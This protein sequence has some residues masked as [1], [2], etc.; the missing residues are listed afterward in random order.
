M[1]LPTGAPSDLGKYPQLSQMS[2]A[3]NMPSI[4]T[5]KPLINM[6]ISMMLGGSGMAPRPTPGQSILEAYQSRERS[7]Q[8]LRTMQTAM[9]S[10]PAFAKFGGMSQGVASIASIV[11]GGPD[12]IMDNP[13]MRAL[14]GGNPI[15]EQMTTMAKL[16]GMTS[17]MGLGRFGNASPATARN[18]AEALTKSV[19]DTKTI[20]QDD[21]NAVRKETAKNV[22]DFIGK[23]ASR[24]ERFKEFMYKDAAGKEQFDTD[25]FEKAR[26]AT[27]GFTKNMKEKLTDVAADEY[28][29]VMNQTNNIND[30]K[31][32]VGNV[33]RVAARMKDTRGFES[34]D[35]Q[36]SMF[37]AMDAGLFRG[38]DYEQ[39]YAADA[40]KRGVSVTDKGRDEY[41]ASAYFKNAPKVMNAVSDLTG[42][43]TMDEATG[44]L[45]D[46]LGNSNIDLGKDADAKYAEDLM[47]RFKASA[48]T[49]G[50]SIEAVMTILHS[51]RALASEHPEL[52]S[53]GGMGGI[54]E[55]TKLMAHGQAMVGAVG[56]DAVR[57]AGG[58][59]AYLAQQQ[60]TQ[61]A[62]KTEPISQQAKALYSFINDGSFDQKTKDAASK[63]LQT[64]LTDPNA[65]YDSQGYSAFLD[66]LAPELGHTSQELFRASLSKGA[67]NRGEEAQ[68]KENQRRRAENLKRGPGDQLEMI[69]L[70]AGARNATNNRIRETAIA[71]IAQVQNES[72]PAAKRNAR[73]EL[74]SAEEIYETE[75][76]GT[77]KDAKKNHMSEL[78]AKNT[79]LNKAGITGGNTDTFIN[80]PNDEQ[81][82]QASRNLF[83]SVLEGTPEYKAIHS[84]AVKATEAQAK[85][86]A[87]YAEKYAKFNGNATA[88]GTLGAELM[89]G[90]LGE[91]TKALTDL[92]VTPEG[93]Q[94][95]DTMLTSVGEM[96]R[97][98][99]VATTAA[100]FYETHGGA[101]GLS[102]DKVR[103]NLKI[104][105]REKDADAIIAQRTG[106]N[107]TDP[108]LNTEEGRKKITEE[109]IQT[110]VK[111]MNDEEKRDLNKSQQGAINATLG[112]LDKTHS[113]EDPSADKARKEEAAKIREALKGLGA[114]SE[115]GKEVE[116][117]DGGRMIDDLRKGNLSDDMQ[118]AL[119]K[120]GQSYV[121]TDEKGRITND[122]RSDLIKDLKE[123]PHRVDPALLEAMQKHPEY[124]K[125]KA[126]SKGQFAGYDMDKLSSYKEQLGSDVTQELS[127]FQDAKTGKY[128]AASL[129]KA[130]KEGKIDTD[131]SKKLADKQLLNKDGTIDAD[132]LQKAADADKQFN[133]LK[134]DSAISSQVVDLQ[135]GKEALTQKET[136]T[137]PLK[138]GMD[139]QV[140]ALKTFS[141]SL[142]DNSASLVAALESI[143]N[144]LR[145]ASK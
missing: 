74:R 57:A 53:M 60:Q 135:R 61:L 108:G 76:L 5:D 100:A 54:E 89:S 96:N 136:E 104:E 92:L 20:G 44:H 47:R 51:T 79:A 16:N 107:P 126:G 106:F 102:E 90:R 37:T 48:K 71:E 2:M 42:A 52:S 59:A 124:V 18:Y 27:S 115:T 31:S 70:D 95:A 68:I 91:G 86:E 13:F 14:N 78:Q 43:K 39:E 121:D 36:K 22:M 15:K 123:D 110:N 143:A 138:E 7:Q 140:D 139:K 105:G 11:S 113:G 98:Q 35:I 144:A 69:D 118:L 66:E 109:A 30:I 99:S 85:E 21:V 122:R 116:S 141:S 82:Q 142:G 4:T 56:Q 83:S 93:K 132:K 19:F 46:L 130:L 134:H 50:V 23:D 6:L 32:K 112:E 125:F 129:N 81:S 101:A 1:I 8:F 28:Q 45:N 75:F 3:P 10:S 49:A 29:K 24:K 73:G 62:N 137:N 63:K 120:Y 133:F 127:S 38:Y 67:S 25:K 58:Q 94:R 84:S 17:T 111:M 87:R 33:S 114:E 97:E 65:K 145:G 9:A 103:A 80:D 26:Q 34:Q 40:K 117:Y 128:N 72:N 64:Y 55:V 88:I 41:T 77:I 131:I 119:K 12:G